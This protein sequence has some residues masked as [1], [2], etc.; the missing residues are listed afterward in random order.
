LFDTHQEAL[1]I[2][3]SLKEDR[4]LRESV[5]KAA[6]ETAEELFSAAVRSEIV[7]FYLR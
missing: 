3:L 6:R 7:E 4:A 2:L 1:E 5:G